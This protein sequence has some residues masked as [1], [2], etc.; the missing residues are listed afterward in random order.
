MEAYLEECEADD[1]HKKM[2]S[3]VKICTIGDG[4]DHYQP[5]NFTG[6]KEMEKRRAVR[7]MGYMMI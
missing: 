3:P 7:V 1:R 2:L 5:S 4:Q 6:D